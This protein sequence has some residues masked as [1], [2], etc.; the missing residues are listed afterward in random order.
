MGA[1]TIIDTP[2]HFGLIGKH[3]SH[4]FSKSYFA[5]KFNALK[6]T[7]YSYVDF[8]F[9]DESELADFLLDAVYKLDGFNV[10]I[11]YKE[12]IIPYLDELHEIADSVQVVNTVKI[13]NNKLIGYNTDIYGFLQAYSSCLHSAQKKALLL[14][15]GGASKSVAFALQSLGLTVTFVSRNSVQTG[16]LSYSEINNETIQSHQIVVNCTPVG[17]FPNT[18]EYPNIPYEYLTKNHTVLDLI[19]NPTETLFLNKAK[20][21]GATTKNGL[22]MLQFQADKAWEIWNT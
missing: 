21:K 12:C 15:T 4:S 8:E 3:L 9:Q 2:K 11:P 16:V 6:L 19:Y 18:D 5:E 14:G 10:T 1:K 17:T 13:V 20:E 7:N 22:L